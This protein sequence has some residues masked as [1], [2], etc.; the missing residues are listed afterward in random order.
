[1]SAA[2]AADRSP[3]LQFVVHLLQAAADLLRL[4]EQTGQIRDAFEH[5]ER[6]R[7]SLRPSL[8]ALPSRLLA[9][10]TIRSARFTS[11]CSAI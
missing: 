3:V 10:R 11:G 4:L 7:S 9:R 2:G 5:V 1:M 8:A 6:P